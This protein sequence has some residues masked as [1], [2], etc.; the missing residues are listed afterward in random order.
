[1]NTLRNIFGIDKYKR[2]KENLSLLTLKLREESRIFQVEIRDLD[3]K[4]NK[5]DSSKKFVKI[6]RTKTESKE[7]ELIKELEVRRKLEEELKGIEGKVK[8]KENFE[9]EIEKSKILLSSKINQL[10]LE[11]KNLQNL[12]LKVSESKELFDEEKFNKVL[13][14]IESKKTEIEELN[15]NHIE[16]SGKMKS[17]ELKKQEDLEKKNR[18]FKESNLEI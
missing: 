15:K 6:L 18:I 9:K 11:E 16:L 5:L 4:K 2:I 10:S 3:E 8:E 7:K 1:M 17:L 12:L 14:E 13:T